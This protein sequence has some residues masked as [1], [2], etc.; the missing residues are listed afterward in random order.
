MS[1]TPALSA[2]DQ[3]VSTWSTRLQLLQLALKPQKVAALSYYRNAAFALS[4]CKEC[5]DFDRLSGAAA[6]A[7]QYDEA[8]KALTETLRSKD[9]NLFSFLSS[10]LQAQPDA[11]LAS[12]TTAIAAAKSANNS[13]AESK[14]CIIRRAH[15]H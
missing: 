3:A 5:R 4:V 15:V 6:A 13:A 11:A 9:P 1:S 7:E 10:S 12:V 14:L 8:A 2:H